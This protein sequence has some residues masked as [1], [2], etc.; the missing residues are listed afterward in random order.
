MLEDGPCLALCGVSACGSDHQAD[1]YAS[2]RMYRLHLGLPDVDTGLER[3]PSPAGSFGRD[4]DVQV[5]DLL[6]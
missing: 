2:Y 4:H 6:P 1:V 3:D 5:P